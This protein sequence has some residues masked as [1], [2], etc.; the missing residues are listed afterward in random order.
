MKSSSVIRNKSGF[1]IFYWLLLLPII[2]A[3]GK[4]NVKE[5]K[6]ERIQEIDEITLY[7]LTLKAENLADSV[8]KS[9]T[10]EEK[11]GQCLMPSINSES[12]P[13]TLNFI[14]ELIDRHHIGGVVL[15]K[16]DMESA[17]K[18]SSLGASAKV[19]LFIS[20]DAEWGLGMRLKDAPCFP[21]NGR[22][23]K[24]VD[25]TLMFDYGREVADECRKTGINMV[26]GPV[27]DLSGLRRGV[28]GSRSFGT[29]PQ[30][31]ADLSV[32]YAKGLES[33]G[34]ISVAKHF[35][36][37]G[38]STI[39]SHKGVAKVTR[40]ISA[41]DTLDF[42]PFRKYINS[43]LTGVMAGHI[44]VPALTPTREPAA[45]SPEI[46]TGLLREEMG[47]KG[48]IMTDAF[49]MGGAKGFSG[50]QALAAGADIILC[51]DDLPKII[52]EIELQLENGELEESLIEEK[53]RRVL[54][55]KALFGLWDKDTGS[56]DSIQINQERVDSLL[57]KMI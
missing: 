51:P 34:V 50:S 57:N 1:I 24:D 47:F 10:L 55:T 48:L 52:R 18:I 32:A 13:Y 33:G 37:H 41:L 53:C 25:E 5:D 29:D 4:T 28:I 46:L 42:L 39:D 9:M 2:F 3:C 44:Q 16:G 40:T 36:G 35:P 27:V 43:G 23:N 19:P 49:N 20:I 17:K 38:S 31:V 45:V 22:I 14:A 21:K 26:L 15:L 12:D 8:L 7:D 56:D 6:E 54:F 30:R 11:I